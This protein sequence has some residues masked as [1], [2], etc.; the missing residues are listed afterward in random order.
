MG[1]VLLFAGKRED[2]FPFGHIEHSNGGSVCGVFVCVWGG[3]G[4][5]YQCYLVLI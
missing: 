5:A 2:T 3:G 4:G 1:Y